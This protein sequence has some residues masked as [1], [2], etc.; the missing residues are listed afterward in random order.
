M[1][2]N[3]LA[4]LWVAFTVITIG[5]AQQSRT[6]DLCTDLTEQGNATGATDT[7]VSSD[8]NLG[9]WRISVRS[10]YSAATLSAIPG[11]NTSS[12]P[13]AEADVWF[14]PFTSTD[15]T[16]GTNWYSACS[17]IFRNLPNNLI[18]RGQ[19]DRGICSQM[20]SSECVH[21]LE[22]R[23]AN[24]ARGLTGN[25]IPQGNLTAAVLDPICSEIRRS[26][27][28]P[29]LA[30]RDEPPEVPL[31]KECD[32][33]FQPDELDPAGLPE[34]F[35]V[36]AYTL[37]SNETTTSDDG[38]NCS[39]ALPNSAKYGQ[40]S[41]SFPRDTGLVGSTY[42][43]FDLPFPDAYDELVHQVWPILTVVFPQANNSRE[44]L[45]DLAYGTMTCLRAR[46]VR[47][48]S[49]VPVQLEDGDEVSFPGA[50]MGSGQIAG[51][52]VGVSVAVLLVLGGAAWWYFR[53]R[54]RNAREAG[55]G[56]R[57]A[58]QDEDARPVMLSE[59]DASPGGAGRLELAGKQ[60]PSEL[61]GQTTEC[62]E[63]PAR[64]EVG[65]ELPAR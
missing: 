60:K 27:G 58:L 59:V 46:D 10:N 5:T 31:P 37:T 52:A 40:Q 8:S 55:S 16:S 64:E 25:P 24:V 17:F 2:K 13:G 20:L 35:I 61:D 57:K 28:E 4:R 56:R 21:A 6:Q 11:V 39:A 36:D 41:Y 9:A 65:K 42:G 50:G 30:S 15:L 47:E 22:E 54:R 3:L 34:M 33:Y 7:T 45:V 49:R 14:D 26:I 38:L 23:T 63:M 1:A 62:F 48:G 43:V 29:S 53:R 32:P 12:S 19:T 44:R 18:R 51:V